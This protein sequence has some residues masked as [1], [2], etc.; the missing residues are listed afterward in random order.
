MTITILFLVPDYWPLLLFPPSVPPFLMTMAVRLPYYNIE[1]G[2]IAS[3]ISG[4]QLRTRYWRIDGVSEHR[5]EPNG[6][7]NGRILTSKHLH[8][9]DDDATDIEQDRGITYAARYKHLQNRHHI[10][11]YYLLYPAMIGRCPQWWYYAA[12]Y[13]EQTKAMEVVGSWCLRGFCEKWSVPALRVLYF[14]VYLST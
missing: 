1:D 8:L 4:V 5:Y 3:S 14:T 13:T 10:I 6:T 9:C 2:G 12:V 11:V 7:R